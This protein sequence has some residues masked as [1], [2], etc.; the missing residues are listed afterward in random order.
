MS[1]SRLPTPRKTIEIIAPLMLKHQEPISL[2]VFPTG[3]SSCVIEWC[4]IMFLVFD[5][6][7]DFA[8]FEKWMFLKL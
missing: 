6:I 1:H 4:Y 2:M 3:S 8:E 7:F 5:Y